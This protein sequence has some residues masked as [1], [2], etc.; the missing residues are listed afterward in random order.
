MKGYIGRVY[1]LLVS[2]VAQSEIF[3]C[4]YQAAHDH[5]GL[6]TARRPDLTGTVEALANIPFGYPSECGQRQ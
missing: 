6:D 2:N 1:E 5:M 4:L 3:D